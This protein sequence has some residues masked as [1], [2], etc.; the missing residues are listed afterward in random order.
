MKKFLAI[1]AALVCC[2]P[3]LAACGGEQRPEGEIAGQYVEMTAAELKEKLDKLEPEKLFGNASSENQAFGVQADAN[4]EASADTQT[5]E[6]GKFV[7]LLKADLRAESD[8][9]ITLT[10]SERETALGGWDVKGKS[11]DKIKGEL[12]PS[13]LLGIDG[14]EDIDYEISAYAD[15]GNLYFQIPDMS[16]LSAEILSEG[17]YSASFDYI[18]DLVTDF[19][20]ESFFSALSGDMDLAEKA[21][22]YKLKSYADE[23]DGLKIKLSANDESFYAILQSLTG[24]SE[25]SVKESATFGTFSLDFYFEADKD[26]A[27]VKAGLVADIDGELKFGADG[28]FEDSPVINGPVKLKADIAVKRSENEIVLPTEAEL[29]SYKKLPVQSPSAR[30]SRSVKK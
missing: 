2:A 24:S 1:A 27:F 4:I 26:G 12:G 21:K 25:E 11:I 23:T 6:S 20:P 5:V 7:T 30:G 8:T 14:T 28:L 18:M 15:G 13:Y 9:Q 29:E 22:E 16:A 3:M 10:P 19:L 17:K